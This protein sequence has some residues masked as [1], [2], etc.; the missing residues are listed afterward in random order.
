MKIPE[1]GSGWAVKTLKIYGNGCYE[2][3]EKRRTLSCNEAPKFESTAL[4]TTWLV[5]KR[6]RSTTISRELSASAVKKEQSDRAGLKSAP[7]TSKFNELLN[8]AN[9]SL[10]EPKKPKDQKRCTRNSASVVNYRQLAKDTTSIA[11][12]SKIITKY[13]EAERRYIGTT[14]ELLKR[15]Q[16]KLNSGIVEWDRMPT[17]RLG[18][19]NNRKLVKRPNIDQE[20]LSHKLRNYVAVKAYGLHDRRCDVEI[21][22]VK[23]AGAAVVNSPDGTKTRSKRVTKFL[24][25]AFEA[26]ADILGLGVPFKSADSKIISVA[27]RCKDQDLLLSDDKPGARSSNGPVLYNGTERQLNIKKKSFQRIKIRCIHFKTDDNTGTVNAVNFEKTGGR[28]SECQQFQ[29]KS[30]D[31][32]LPKAPPTTP[33]Q[34]QNSKKPKHSFNTLGVSDN[35]VSHFHNHRR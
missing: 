32:K 18:Y 30:H 16:R 27:E 2:M 5:S 22:A 6:S 26:N 35:S 3:E 28:C 34:R 31:L 25:E 10:V 11:D 20:E 1:E 8:V 15:D 23:N 29:E 33:T 17:R 14:I 4:N 24:S 7:S 21:N 19:P 13:D 12:M 9:L